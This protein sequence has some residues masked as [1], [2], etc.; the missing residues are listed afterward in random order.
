MRGKTCYKTLIA[1]AVILLFTTFIFAGGRKGEE[2]KESTETKAPAATGESVM[3]AKEDVVPSHEEMMASMKPF[4]EAAK[5]TGAKTLRISFQAGADVQFTNE[6]KD[7]W[8]KATG[9]KILVENIPPQNMHE[10]LLMALSGS[11]EFDAVD[12]NPTFIGEW[13]ES[14]FIENLEP[15]YQKYKHLLDLSDFIEAFY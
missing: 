5:A 1:L 7:D 11:Y 6:F 10:R 3:V 8:E 12:N 4:A 14:G 15:Y 2:V 9:I 13:A